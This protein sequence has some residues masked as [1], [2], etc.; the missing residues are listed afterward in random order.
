MLETLPPLEQN[1]EELD[2]D[3]EQHICYVRPMESV[4]DYMTRVQCQ[5]FW[6]T[7]PRTATMLQISTEPNRSS[8]NLISN[9]LS[10]KKIQILEARAK[11]DTELR[12][13]LDEVS[14]KTA[15]QQQTNDLQIRQEFLAKRKTMVALIRKIKVDRRQED[16]QEQI[17]YLDTR[18]NEDARREPSTSLPHYDNMMKEL[19][20]FEKDNNSK[21]S[22]MASSDE[23][24]V[25]MAPNTNGNRTAR[26]NLCLETPDFN[27]T[28]KEMGQVEDD[29]D[30][31]MITAPEYQ[32]D[33]MELDANEAKGTTI[34]LCSCMVKFAK[35]QHDLMNLDTSRNEG[36]NEGAIDMSLMVQASMAPPRVWTTTDRWVDNDHCVEAATRHDLEAW[37]DW[38]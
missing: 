18:E 1:P 19:E 34:H 7:S 20:D 3:D 36:R 4:A 5:V 12:A 11:Q 29:D 23:E 37:Q 6:A 24:E 13:L 10:T 8:V 21:H 28:I 27:D 26:N 25:V 33:A 38:V 35:N 9:T 30:S 31:S 17:L 15:S 14:S 32:D 16:F 2:F 22:W